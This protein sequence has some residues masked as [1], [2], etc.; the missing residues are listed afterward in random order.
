M[1]GYSDN[2][3]Y[4]HHV[5]EFNENLPKAF[6]REV[7]LSMGST[8][9]MS[10]CE[11]LLTAQTI[12]GEKSWQEIDRVNA[13]RL[14]QQGHVMDHLV[15]FGERFCSEGDGEDGEADFSGCGPF[16]VIQ[17]MCIV[18]DPGEQHHRAILNILSY[19]PLKRTHAHF[20]A[21][22]FGFI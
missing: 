10:T 15:G 3:N 16:T 9:D 1:V 6:G 21:R 18:Q 13:E 20:A 7:D 19:H 22:H 17:C 8:W 5:A 4:F 14:Q 11:G 12:W 2:A